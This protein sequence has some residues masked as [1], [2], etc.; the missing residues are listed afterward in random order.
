[1]NGS[2]PMNGQEQSIEI[3]A[4]DFIPEPQADCVGD[5]N[6]DGVVDGADLGLLIGGWGTTGL[7]DLNGDESIDGADLGLMIGAWGVCP[8]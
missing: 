2:P 7:G 1:M 3:T 4:F 5:L 6:G 8:G